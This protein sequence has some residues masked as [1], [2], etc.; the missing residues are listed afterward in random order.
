M[1]ALRVQL[2]RA[3]AQKDVAERESAVLRA[4]LG[5]ADL[6]RTVCHEKLSAFENHNKATAKEVSTKRMLC[7]DSSADTLVRR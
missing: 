7:G 2:R 3:D 5:Q 6:H 4:K 1:S